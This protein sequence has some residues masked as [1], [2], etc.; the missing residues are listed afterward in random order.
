MR[1]RHGSP[2]GGV[3]PCPSNSARPPATWPIQGTIVFDHVSTSYTDD[4]NA[5]TVLHDLSFRIRP[6]EKVG[7]IGRTGAG[8]SSL[9]QILFRMGYVLE[10]RILIDDINIGD[11]GVDDVRSRLSIIPQ[12]PVL[13]T[14]TMR[15]NLDPFNDYS[16]EQIWNALEQVCCYSNFRNPLVFAFFDEKENVISIL[17]STENDSNNCD[18]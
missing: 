10:G 17:G 8:K 9:I 6:S 12:D 11:I 14:G 15:H 16:D 13:F 4:E 7:I 3:A 18:V 5:V 1:M 2:A